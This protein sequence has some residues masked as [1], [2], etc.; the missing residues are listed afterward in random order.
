MLLTDLLAPPRVV[1]PLRGRTKPAVIRELLVAA[2][3]AAPSTD[4]DVVM[5]ALL[6]RESVL[7]TGIGDGVA[8]PHAKT[9]NVDRLVMAAGVSRAPIDFD[10]LDGEPADVFFLLLG[11][12]TAPTE[13]VKALGR[14]ARVLRRPGLL[15]ALRAARDGAAFVRTVAE[16]ESG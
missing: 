6:A 13:H 7:S 10:A 1:L 5:D 11:P 9:P 15:D 16:T 12:E 8:I 2:L 14:L 3:P 4:V